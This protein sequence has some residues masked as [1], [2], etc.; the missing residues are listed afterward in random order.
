MEVVRARGASVA[1]RSL[2]ATP[3]LARPARRVAGRARCSALVVGF[4][5][6]QLG[7]DETPHGRGDGGQGDCRR[8]RRQPRDRGRRARRSRLHDMPDPRARPRLPGLGPAR[9]PAGARADL[10]GRQRRD[11]ERSRCPGPERRRRRAGHARARAAAPRAERDAD[12]ER[13][14]VARVGLRSMEICYRHPNRETGVRCSNCERPICPDCMTSTPV[15]MRCPECARQRTKVRAIGTLG[16]RAGAH[17]HPDRDQRGGAR[18]DRLGGASATRRRASA[19]A[20]CSRTARV[21]R[22]RDRRRRVLAAR[23]RRLPARR[24]LPPAVQHALALDPRL[25]A[26]AGG[27]EACASGSSTSCRCSPARSARCCVEPDALDGGRLGRDLRPDGRG[28]RGRCATAASTCME[29][30]LGIWIGLNLLITFTVPNISIGGHIGGPDR[31]RAGRA[32]AG[33]AARARARARRRAGAACASRWASLAVVGLD[34]G[35]RAR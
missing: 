7:G 19:A 11:R 12:R 24:L 28:G 33:R 2:R 22:R 18:G 26:R 9:R 34:R 10:R 14:A 30:G 29:S 35:R 13:A 16:G 23:H 8:R 15:G 6:A 31:R 3:A 5:V 17:L 21:S 20:A 27:R 32:R 4:G 1:D 25:A